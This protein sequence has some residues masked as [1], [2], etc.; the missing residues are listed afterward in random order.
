MNTE[1]TKNPDSLLSL[2]KRD[3]LRGKEGKLKIF[4]GMSA[5]VGKTFSMLQAA[6]KLK[7]RGVDIAIGLVETHGRKDTAA[8]V[9]GLEILPRKHLAYKGVTVEELDLDAILARKP[10][11]I[12][13][14]ELA[15]TNS[16]GS[17]HAKR[18]LDVLEILKAGIDVFTTLNVQ[19]IESRVDTVQEITKITVFETIPDV[20]LDRADEIILIDLT[21]EELLTRLGDG[22]IYAEESA[23]LAAQNFFKQGNLTALREMALRVAA[24]RVDRDL[25]DYK[26]LHGIE[27]VWKTSGRLMVAVFA[28]PYSE[29]LIRWTRRVADLLGVTWIGAYVESDEE[30]TDEE[31][32]LLSKNI[33]LVQQSGGEVISTRD[34]DPVNG[35]LRIAQQNNVTQI[36]V[37]KSQRSLLKTILTGGSLVNRLLRQSGN[38]DVYAVSTSRAKGR[39]YLKNVFTPKRSPLK[40]EDFGWLAAI[41]L[42]TWALAAVM[43]PLIGYMAVGIIFLLS[44]SV[45]GL[46]IARPAVFTLAFLFALIH[47]FFFIPPKLTWNIQRPEDFMLLL[48]LFVAAAV[49]GHLTTR[50]THKEKVLRSR[51]DRANRLYSLAKEIASSQSVPEILD[52]AQSQLETALDTDVFI[53]LKPSNLK[54]SGLKA[55]V[56]FSLTQKEEAVATWVL[57]NGKI[58][59]HSTETLSGSENTYVPILGQSGVL[60]VAGINTSKQDFELSPDQLT[61][62]DTF[63]HQIASG[64]ERETFHER[65]KSLLVMEETQ[66]LYK[67]LLDCVSHEL[68][69]PLAAIKGSASAILDPMT[70]TNPI[71]VENL[72]REI[73]GA[74]ERLQRL[75][76]NLLDMTRIESGMM[77]PKRELCDASDIIS[78]AIRSID[79]L[80]AGRVFQINASELTPP[81]LCDPVLVNQALANILHN[82]LLYTPKSSPIDISAYAGQDEDVVISI[83]DHGPGLP[84][85]NP[86]S[87]LQKFFRADQSHAG[88]VGLGLSIAKGFIEAQG[89]SIT[90]SNHRD[91]GAV[92]TMHLPR[93]PHQ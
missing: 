12:L 83:R 92:F 66:K 46:F 58:A 61:L 19:H 63:L 27:G 44:V 28:S 76:E 48:M 70:S 84:K 59:G 4:L 3:E 25:R 22:Q 62:I 21:P 33:A 2:I 56:N 50:L 52:R 55:N 71:A 36:I 65:I 32:R 8:L 17:R 41:T 1:D 80:K 31:K 72:G 14:D 30:K 51:E 20:I 18:Y 49:I 35:L 42:A 23:R 6:H 54:V 38:I 16:P 81:V 78:T 37:G 69:T 24:E 29:V 79:H 64:I 87:V 47:N 9:E 91:G 82:A 86:S 40:S 57:E 15:H 68:K 88:G 43:Q 5:G 7:G 45:S 34:D 89:G 26:T 77:R 73:L 11:I 67:S 60:G 93:G 39:Q 90:A 75:V 53:L 10:K 74:S 85:E 13:V